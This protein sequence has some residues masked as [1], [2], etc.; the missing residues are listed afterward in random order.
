MRDAREAQA[1]AARL[2]TK[3]DSLNGHLIDDARRRSPDELAE[4]ITRHVADLSV[5]ED[6]ALVG[7]PERDLAER[8]GGDPAAISE[9]IARLPDREKIV[10]SLYYYDNLSM[11]DIGEVLGV[12]ESRVNQLHKKAI[13]RLRGA[14]A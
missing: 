14:A 8:I 2:E 7:P 4:S 3:V 9:L 5:S 13:E 10:V 1:R 11:R 6:V 12:S